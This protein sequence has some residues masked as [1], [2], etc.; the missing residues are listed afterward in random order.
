VR[1]A[2][3][4]P[5]LSCRSLSCGQPPCSLDCP[6]GLGWALSLGLPGSDGLPTQAFTHQ[7]AS[8]LPA[9]WAPR[10]P[11]PSCSPRAVG[12]KHMCCCIKGP[13]ASRTRTHSGPVHPCCQHT[14]QRLLQRTNCPGHAGHPTT[15]AA[16]PTDTA[17]AATRTARL[18]LGSR[19]VR[20]VLPQPRQRPCQGLGSASFTGPRSPQACTGPGTSTE[21][22]RGPGRAV[23]S[24]G[25]TL[26]CTWKHAA[27]H[28]ATV[29]LLP[30]R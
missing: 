28:T 24:L 4:Q 6:R 20:L 30:P 10:T 26:G 18:P 25:D 17:R 7:S 29:G 13:H 22:Q 3:H 11:P 12:G 9:S 19:R 27:L 5:G 21:T 15:A 1:A 2:K 14:L 23:T 8:P 16:V